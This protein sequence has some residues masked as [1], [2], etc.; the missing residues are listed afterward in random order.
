MLRPAVERAHAG[1]AAEVEHHGLAARGA[2]VVRGQHRR[3][4]LVRQPVE[5][6]AAH[7]LVLQLLRQREHLL[8]ARERP[9]H[10][11]VE[12]R[13]LRQLRRARQHRPDRGQVVRAGAAA[14]AG[15]ASPPWRARLASTRV[16]VTYAVAAVGD[17]VTDRDQPMRAA[18]PC[19]AASRRCGRTRRRGRAARRPASASRPAVLPSASFATKRGV[20]PSPSTWP[21]AISVELRVTQREH[22]ELDARRAG[23][24]DQ[25]RVG[26]RTP[27]AIGAA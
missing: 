1:A 17:T 23:V 4:V 24:Q 16:G 9:V 27:H 14:R 25:D 11:G 15:P 18:A 3:D 12:A 19:F 22:G 7:A 6:V 26:H 5:T 8:D 2:L 13:H 20:V 21:L 10:R